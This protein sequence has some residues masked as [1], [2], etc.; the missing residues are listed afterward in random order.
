MKTQLQEKEYYEEY[1]KE[2]Y[3]EEYAKEH[4]KEGVK[5]DMIRIQMKKSSTNCQVK[6]RTR[7]QKIQAIPTFPKLVFILIKVKHLHAWKAFQATS[8]P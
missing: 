2:Y 7:S 8:V 4:G 3:G 1:A 6:F 5:E